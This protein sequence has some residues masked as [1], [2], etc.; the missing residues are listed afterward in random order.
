M[1]ATPRAPRRA[2]GPLAGPTSA[3]QG[4]FLPISPGSWCGGSVPSSLD[5]CSLWLTSLIKARDW[6]ISLWGPRAGLQLFTH[7]C[8][9]FPVNISP[10]HELINLLFPETKKRACGPG[11]APSGS[12]RL[13]TTSLSLGLLESRVLRPQLGGGVQPAQGIPRVE[14]AWPEP[15]ESIAWGPCESDRPGTCPTYGGPFL[16]PR[17]R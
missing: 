8:A 6:N 7:F 12:L 13:E 9:F 14:T 5:K 15:G 4:P 16:S 11:W 10:F 3:P 17:P 2:Q 1:A